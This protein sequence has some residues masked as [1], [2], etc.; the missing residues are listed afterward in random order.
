MCTLQEKMAKLKQHV[1]QQ[2]NDKKNIRRALDDAENRCTQ[3][4]LLR[5]SQDG[6]L[7]RM[8]LVLTD[9]ETENQVVN[10]CL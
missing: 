10:L 1:D 9:K 8:R 7:Q 4:E 6:D 5:R 3:L 2:E